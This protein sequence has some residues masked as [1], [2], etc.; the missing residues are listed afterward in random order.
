MSD[1]KKAQECVADV[2]E[3]IPGGEQAGGSYR[4]KAKTVLRHEIT[5]AETQCRRAGMRQIKLQ[6]LYDSLPENLSQEADEALWELLLDARR[7]L[8]S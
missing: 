1:A 7:K 8:V 4:E 5:V 3:G 2:A 6:A